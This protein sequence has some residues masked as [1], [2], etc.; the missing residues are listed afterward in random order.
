MNLQDTFDIIKEKITS[1]TET[2][3]DFFEENRK[4]GIMVVS[5][6]LVILICIVLLILSLSSEKN[7]KNNSVIEDILYTTENP[8]IPNGPEVPRDYNFSRK[9]K[10][11]WSDE[12]SQ[13]WFSTPSKVEI[14]SLSNTNDNMV[15][16]II[17]AAP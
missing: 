4:I 7:K 2:V 13:Q 17:K 15:N 8:L 9:T 12:D 6:I 14:D 10:S 11:E 1:L 16:E 5:L 3:S